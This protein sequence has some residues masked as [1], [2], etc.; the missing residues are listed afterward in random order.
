MI[1]NLFW[2][3]N[4]VREKILEAFVLP[5]L[6]ISYW[7]FLIILAVVGVVI[8]VL[9]NSVQVSGSAAVSAGKNS[10]KS[11]KR[12]RDRNL[13]YRQRYNAEARKK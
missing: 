6:G 5:E 12:R 3:L 7:K 8:T 1:S 13:S 2:I 11:F 9:I 4:E 10:Y